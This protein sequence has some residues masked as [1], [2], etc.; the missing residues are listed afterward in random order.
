MAGYPRIS[1]IRASYVVC[2][3]GDVLQYVSTKSCIFIGGRNDTCEPLKRT[4]ITAHISH[5]PVQTVSL[6]THAIG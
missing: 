5:K 3:I 2:V 4:L 1:D 6:V